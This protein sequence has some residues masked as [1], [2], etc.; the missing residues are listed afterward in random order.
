MFLYSIKTTPSVEQSVAKKFSSHNFKKP[1][2]RDHTNSA[3]FA[4]KE[5]FVVVADDVDRPNLYVNSI[6]SASKV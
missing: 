4:M 1:F 5:I 6:I 3:R 2:S